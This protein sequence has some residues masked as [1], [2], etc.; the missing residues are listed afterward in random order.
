MGV[1][2]GRGSLKVSG[3]GLSD[4]YVLSKYKSILY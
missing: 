1:G 2:W 4:G 3:S